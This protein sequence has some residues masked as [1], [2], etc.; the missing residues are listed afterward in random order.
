MQICCVFSAGLFVQDSSSSLLLRSLVESLERNLV[1]KIQTSERGLLAQ[2]QALSDKLADV[3]DRLD[4]LE[5]QENSYN[6]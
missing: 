5:K 2:I 3:E 6:L 1:S 4:L